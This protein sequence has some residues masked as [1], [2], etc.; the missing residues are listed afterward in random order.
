[1]GVHAVWRGHVNKPLRYFKPCFQS[2]AVFSEPVPGMVYKWAAL[3]DARGAI[4]VQGDR[5]PMS[6]VEWLDMT[7]PPSTRVLPT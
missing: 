1:M 5:L 7:S 6:G 3:T 2:D 4:G